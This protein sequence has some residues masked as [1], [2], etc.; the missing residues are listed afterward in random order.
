MREDRWQTSWE[1]GVPR[2]CIQILIPPLNGR[3]TS[4]RLLGLL[5]PLVPHLHTGM[6]NVVQEFSNAMHGKRWLRCL[7]PSRRLMVGAVTPP[8]QLGTAF[9]DPLP[10]GLPHLSSFP[11][12]LSLD[13]IQCLSPPSAFILSVFTPLLSAPQLGLPREKRLHVL[14]TAVCSAAGTVPGT[15]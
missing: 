9:P 4:D 10:Q 14:L 11:S 6:V 2:T 5:E 8:R 15:Q 1:A 3:V 7:L 13:L 12:A